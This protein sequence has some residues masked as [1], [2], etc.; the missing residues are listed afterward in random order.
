MRLGWL[1]D[2]R[3]RGV[4]DVRRHVR[5]HNFD[6]DKHRTAEVWL[7]WQDHWLKLVGVIMAGVMAVATVVGMF[8]D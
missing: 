4:D 6:P 2:F 7:W 3:Q 5:A 8:G 1:R